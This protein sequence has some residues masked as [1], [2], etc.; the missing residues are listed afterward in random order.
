MV[1]DEF[2]GPCTIHRHRYCAHQTRVH[3]VS[4][5]SDVYLISSVEA[6]HNNTTSSA[7][8]IFHYRSIR[9]LERPSQRQSQCRNGIFPPRRDLVGPLILTSSP[10][11]AM[12]ISIRVT[13]SPS[14]A[15][16]TLSYL[17]RVIRAS[18]PSTCVF[19]TTYKECDG[20]HEP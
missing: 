10:Y 18:P 3:I 2:V 6:V 15:M 8:F 7:R 20:R 9:F 13:S 19:M 1:V 11:R 4:L 5:W 17:R 12:V 14:R 16:M